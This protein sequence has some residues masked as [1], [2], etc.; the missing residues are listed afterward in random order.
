MFEIIQSLLLHNSNKIIPEPFAYEKYLIAEVAV[1]HP[2]GY[3]T[4]IA[5]QI[6]QG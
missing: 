5:I 6:I 2:D 1:Q 4:Q 3:V